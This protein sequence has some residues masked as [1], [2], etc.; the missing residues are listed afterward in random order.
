MQSIR[1]LFTAAFRALAA[2]T[3]PAQERAGTRKRGSGHPR[4]PPTGH[5]AK[6]R[7]LRKLQ[8]ASRRSN[9]G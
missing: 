5:Q 4:K 6:R 1:E 3:H 7:R 9:R 8:K 2:G